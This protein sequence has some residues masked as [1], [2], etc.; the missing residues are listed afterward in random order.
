MSAPIIFCIFIE[1]SGFNNI[2]DE[3]CGDIN[4]TPS[5]VTFDK[6]FIMFYN[7]KIPNRETI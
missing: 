5:S 2:S 7:L 3:S 1:S 6:S 4:D